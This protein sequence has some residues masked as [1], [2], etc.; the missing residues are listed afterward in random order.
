LQAIAEDSGAKTVLTTSSLLSKVKAQ[1]EF[2]NLHSLASDEVPDEAADR[3]SPPAITSDALACLQYTSGSTGKPKGVILT[4]ENLLANASAGAIA[5]AGSSADKLVSW[6]PMFHDMGFMIGVLQPV[7][8]GI[9]VI[10]MA[11]AAFIQHPLRWLTAI[12]H[13]AGTVSGAPNFAFELCVEKITEAEKQ[14][15]DLSSWRVAFN[16]SEPVR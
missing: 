1:A 2:K 8:A 13:Y 7:W 9:S 4:H 3:W 6:L 11:P 5:L 14:H 16:G 12:S 10:S 15:I